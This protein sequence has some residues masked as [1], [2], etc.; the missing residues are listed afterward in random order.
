LEDPTAAGATW[1]IP[2]IFEVHFGENLGKL[3]K[4]KKYRTTR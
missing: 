4:L 2:A 3:G 1:V